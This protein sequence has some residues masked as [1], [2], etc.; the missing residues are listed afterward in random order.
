MLTASIVLVLFS[1]AWCQ[2]VE[3]N[4]KVV[5]KVLPAYPQLARTMNITGVV[6]LEVVVTSNGTVKSVGVKGGHPVLAEAATEAV[7]Q[8]RWERGAQETTEYVEM[9]FNPR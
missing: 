3:N 7:N 8:W 1:P 9:R 6:K 5:A 2:Q 4:R